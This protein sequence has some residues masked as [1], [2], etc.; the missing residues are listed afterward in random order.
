MYYSHNELRKFV[1]AQESDYRTALSEIKSGRKRSHW[2]WYIFPQLQGLG[3]SP[4]ANYYGI[5]D[6]TQAREYLAHPYLGANLLEISGALLNTDSCNP[7]EV[8]GYPD[9]LK[10]CSCMTLFE[11]ADPS[12]EVFG[13]V[14]DK[15]YHGRRDERTLSMLKKS[16]SK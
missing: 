2:M 9:D 13:M 10:L 6:I 3:M 8:M 11:A 15:F 7:S 5:K 16:G 1:T 12:K 4:T 14:L